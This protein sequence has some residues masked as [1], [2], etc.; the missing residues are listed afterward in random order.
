VKREGA[1]NVTESRT[2]MTRVGR[3][4][5]AATLSA[6]G[7]SLVEPSADGGGR[8][9]DGGLV[10]GDAGDADGPPVFIDDICVDAARTPPLL[11]CDPFLPSSCPAGKGCYAVPPRASGACQPG[12]FGTIC[13]AEG[14][15]A[16]GVPCSDTTECLSSHVCVKSGL[17]NHCA[18]LCKVSE[19]GSCSD[20]RVCRLLDL[21][22]SGWGGCE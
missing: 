19:L 15:G 8:H 3:L 21:S 2:A 4:L 12:T 16:Q 7:G 10:S 6:C 17:G 1:D 5:F 11:V 13:S 22:G 18:K 14:R 20:G 9:R